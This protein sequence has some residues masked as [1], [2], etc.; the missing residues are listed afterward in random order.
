MAEVKISE[1]PSLVE[2]EG[3]VSVDT[4]WP[5]AAE[6]ILTADPT[7]EKKWLGPILFRTS[8]I[9]RYRS[10]LPSFMKTGGTLLATESVRA[11]QSQVVSAPTAPEEFDACTCPAKSN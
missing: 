9:G 6:W 3:M 1:R 5:V 11:S 4:T 2:F 8:S 10:H 7:R